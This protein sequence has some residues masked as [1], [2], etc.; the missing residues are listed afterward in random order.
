MNNKNPQRVAV[1]MSG[2]F[3][4]F[5]YTKDTFRTHVIEPLK[6]LGYLV[7]LYVC[8]TLDDATKSWEKSSQLT[9]NQTMIRNAFDPFQPKRVSWIEK[10]EAKSVHKNIRQAYGI[11]KCFAL[12]ESEHYDYYIRVRPDYY[13]LYDIP[14]PSYVGKE[15]MVHT[16]F[17]KH[18]KGCDLIFTMSG[19]TYES[20]WV[21]TIRPKI[22]TSV[23]DIS[24][25]HLGWELE[26]WLFED[27]PVH[28]DKAFEGGILRE[29]RYLVI[30]SDIGYEKSLSPHLGLRCEYRVGKYAF[31]KYCM[32]VLRS[33][34]RKLI[35]LLIP[36]LQG[37]KH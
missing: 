15:R 24:V 21:S 23:K 28:K 16:G 3:R 22:R 17:F 34:Y 35:R 5:A 33:W 7:D 9:D 6:R 32:L 8:I 26:Q 25:H 20:W 37:L 1:C 10:E 12:T 18:A 31:L 2:G 36:W 30:W 13:Y 14:D 11:D 4:T 27:I 29:G 19:K